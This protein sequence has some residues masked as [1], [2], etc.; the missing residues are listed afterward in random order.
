MRLFEITSKITF[1]DENRNYHHGQA[2]QTL[3]AYLGK[4]VIGYINYSIYQDEPHVQYI[5]IDPDMRRRGYGSAMVRQLQLMFPDVE[6]DM[7][8]LTDDGSKL[9]S[10]MPQRTLHSSEYKEKLDQLSALK[11][12]EAEYNKLADAFYANPT[13]H[14]REL[15]HQQTGDWNELHD[16]MWELEQELRD[17]KPSRRLFTT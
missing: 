15:L 9:L 7:G 17:M 12:K 8:G 13:D 5:H 16:A 3:R 14:A 10:A 4:K 6:I 1:R 11:A 2:D